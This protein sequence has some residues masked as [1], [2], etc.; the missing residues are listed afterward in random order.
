MDP[1]VGLARLRFGAAY[2][3]WQG[4]WLR[5]GIS[6]LAALLTLD[7]NEAF[8]QRPELSLGLGWALR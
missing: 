7:S 6:W 8:R 3:L 1:S 4:L 5:A 2:K